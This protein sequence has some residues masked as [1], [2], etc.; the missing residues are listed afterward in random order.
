[1]QLTQQEVRFLIRALK[2]IQ[3]LRVDIT[4]D[5]MDRRI[6]DMV[7]RLSEGVK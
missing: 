6:E 3:W 7:R 2:V 5:D 4:G 1:M